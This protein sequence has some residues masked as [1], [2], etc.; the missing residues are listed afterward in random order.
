M[1]D[2]EVRIGIWL[3]HQSKF[4]LEQIDSYDIVDGVRERSDGVQTFD[5]ALENRD[6]GEIAKASSLDELD[7][8]DEFSPWV[9]SVS[10][11]DE[12]G[13]LQHL[14]LAFVLDGHQNLSC[15][16]LLLVDLFF[17]FVQ[18]SFSIFGVGGSWR[19]KSWLD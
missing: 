3:A 6:H 12:V 5:V 15:S 14:L 18:I 17:C 7:K 2:D 9:C 11:E 4:L 13:V 1:L 16:L 19:G 10:V 8:G